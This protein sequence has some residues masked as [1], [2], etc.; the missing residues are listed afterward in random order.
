MPTEK[1]PRAQP[2]EPAPKRI[3]PIPFDDE[4]DEPYGDPSKVK[5]ESPLKSLGEAVSD[6]VRERGERKAGREGLS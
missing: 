6:P 5:D 1:T 3:Q 2:A 4:D